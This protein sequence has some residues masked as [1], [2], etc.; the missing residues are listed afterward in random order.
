MVYRVRSDSVYSLSLI[1]RYFRYRFLSLHPRTTSVSLP[2][3]FARANIIKSHEFVSSYLLGVAVNAAI[4]IVSAAAFYYTDGNHSQMIVADLFSAH[5]L[6]ATRMGQASSYVF[7]IAL[8][9][10]GQ[11]ASIT[12]TMAGQIVSEGFLEWRTNPVVRRMVTRL[13]GIVPA[14]AVAG[15]VGLKGMDSLLVGSQVALSLVLP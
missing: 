8:L 11:A 4:L 5:E 15:S 3:H 13:I 7:A 12:V 6:L 14:A 1:S 9:L 2:L 10:S